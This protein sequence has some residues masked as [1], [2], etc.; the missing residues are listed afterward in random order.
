MT[1]F[2]HAFSTSRVAHVVRTSDRCVH[3]GEEYSSPPPKPHAPNQGSVCVGTVSL[4]WVCRGAVAMTVGRY[5]LQDTGERRQPARLPG[6]QGLLWE[7]FWHAFPIGLLLSGLSGY[8]SC[9]AIEQRSAH[10]VRLVSSRLGPLSAFLLAAKPA[11]QPALG[12]V[13]ALRDLLVEFIERMVRAVPA[14][15]HRCQLITVSPRASDS[16]PKTAPLTSSPS[17]P[18]QSSSPHPSD[19]PRASS[20]PCASPASRP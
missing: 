5:E 7:S 3:W 8:R 11:A 18:H 12:L 6:P 4:A 15:T 13:R 19:T 2:N 16:P 20:P 1:A 9:L 14:I 17:T 10:H